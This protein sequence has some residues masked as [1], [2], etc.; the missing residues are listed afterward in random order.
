MLN[1]LCQCPNHV[2]CAGILPNL[3]VEGCGKLQILGIGH[4]V[5]QHDRRSYGRKAIKGLGITILASTRARELEVARAHIVATGIAEDVGESLG[6]GD[7]F[8]VAADDDG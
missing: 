1:N 7:I 5:S 8:R 6:S 4:G 3:S 2:I